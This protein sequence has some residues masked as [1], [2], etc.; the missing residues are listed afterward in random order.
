MSALLFLGL[1]FGL[2]FGLMGISI[3]S[4]AQR[5]SNYLFEI[6]P[7]LGT[8]LPYDSWGIPGTLSVIGVR[9]FVPIS[10]PNGV[11]ASVLYQ[12]AGGDTAY[13]IDASYRFEVPTEAFISFFNIGYHYSI[14]DLD[15]DYDAAGVCVPTSCAT[16]SGTHQ[17][18]V[19]GAGVMAPLGTSTMGRLGMRFYKNPVTWLLLEA[20]LGFRF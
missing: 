11:E 1:F 18:I 17:G 14:F 8:N 10:G 7:T 3:H 5:G 4:W 6:A 15:V 12:S 9:G 20:G 19:F 13:T 2:F 16:D